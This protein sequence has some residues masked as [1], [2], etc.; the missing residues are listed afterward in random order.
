MVDTA[1]TIFPPMIWVTLMAILWTLWTISAQ[2]KT[3]LT[4]PTL[5]V[6]DDFPAEE[7]KPG[8]IVHYTEA[9]TYA[10]G[11]RV[12]VRGNAGF[13]RGARGV[14]V[15]QEPNNQRCWVVRD[16]TTSPVF[17]YNHELVAE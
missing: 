15:F 2:L 8:P 7:L 9:P 17:F 13:H 16:H 10:P 11:S 5:V 3:L 6:P 12:R 14:V 1:I 4:P